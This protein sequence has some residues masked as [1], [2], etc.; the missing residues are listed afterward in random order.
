M[1]YVPGMQKE[2][3]WYGQGRRLAET[4]EL[5]QDVNASGLVSANMFDS[6][7]LQA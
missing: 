5:E 1:S 2:C 3:H 7:L 6:Q 4:S